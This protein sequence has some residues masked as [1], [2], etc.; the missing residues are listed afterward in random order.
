[1]SYI[2]ENEIYKDEANSLK[3]YEEIAGHGLK[4]NYKGKVV[5]AGNKKDGIDEW[6]KFLDSIFE[7][8]EK[9]SF[10]TPHASFPL[11]T[12]HKS[13]YSSSSISFNLACTNLIPFKVFCNISTQSL[14]KCQA[15]STSFNLYFKIKLI[16]TILKTNIEITIAGRVNKSP[17]APIIGVV[18]LSGSQPFSKLFNEIKYEQKPFTDNFNFITEAG[19]RVRSKSEIMIADALSRNKIPFKYEM[20]QILSNNNQKV[21]FYPDF[22][23]LN[24]K[25]HEIFL[26]EHLGIMDN[27]EYAENAIAKINIYQKNG[28]CPGKNLILSMETK[29]NPLSSKMVAGLIENYF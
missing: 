27:D 3:D 5:L 26:W 24:H 21:I 6:E 15:W 2:C 1:M 19:I 23:C 20:P 14:V 8:N 29:N 28:F 11:E 9:P 16:L 17:N 7:N 13:A 25:T 10:D 18:T 12:S 22:T 4:V